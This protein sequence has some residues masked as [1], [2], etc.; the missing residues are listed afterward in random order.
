MRNIFFFIRKFANFLFFLLLQIIALYFL[1]RYNKFHQAAFQNVAGELT[2]RV[3]ERYNNVEYYFKLKKTNE[4]L[5]QQNEKLL[6]LLKQ[7]YEP[8]DTAK[9]FI[10]DTLR[11]DSLLSVQRFKYYGAKVVNNTVIFSQN[12]FMTI[13]RGS[14]QGLPA[15]REWGVISPQGIAGRVISV[16]DNF[17]VVM[18]VLNHQFKVYAM[19][20][21]GG[22]AGPVSW[23]DD[24]PEMLR[25]VNIPKSAK[26]AKGD[27]VLTS[28]VSDIFPPG[29]VVGTIAEII[30]PKSSNFF[31]LKLKPAT[32][33][34]NLQ[35][36]YVV[37]DLQRDEREKLEESTK[38]V[39]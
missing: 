26:V 32:N 22:E 27:T 8:A 1:F 5:A 39:K 30:E 29:V 20:K 34:S 21:N 25:L 24:N 10:T 3:S 13:H 4:A 2:G 35:Y 17:T 12:N 19:L 33:F 7:N 15:N 18:S 16:G 9:Q 6:N 14:K 31:T 28:N 11:I 37:E 38:K 36:V 23:D